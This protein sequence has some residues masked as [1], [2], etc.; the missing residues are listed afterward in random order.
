MNG[1]VNVLC[2]D[3]EMTTVGCYRDYDIRVEIDWCPICGKLLKTTKMGEIID[4]KI[5]TPL[6]NFKSVARE[7]L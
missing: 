2:C 6:D 1:V 5:F 7:C 4:S 3:H